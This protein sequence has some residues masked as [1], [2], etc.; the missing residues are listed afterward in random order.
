MST[1]STPSHPSRDLRAM[2]RNHRSLDKNQMFSFSPRRH[3]RREG[4]TLEDADSR[5]A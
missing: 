2:C 5:E 4:V 3:D 1:F